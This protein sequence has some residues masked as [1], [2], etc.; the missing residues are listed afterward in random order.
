[1]SAYVIDYSEPLVTGF[2]IPAGG[3]NGPGGSQTNSTLRLYGRGALEWGEAVDED[4]LRLAENFASASPPSAAIAGQ[5]WVQTKLYVRN[6]LTGGPQ[7]GW[8]RYDPNAKTWSLLSGA[9]VAGGVVP[10]S[11]PVSPVV[12]SY[13]YGTRSVGTTNPTTLTGLWGYYSLG[14]YEPAAWV[15]RWSDREPF[16]TAGAPVNGVTL[17]VQRLRVRNAYVV[18]GDGAWTVPSTT[19]FSINAVTPIA[20][21]IGNL[22]FVTDTGQLRVYNG[23][24]WL[25]IVGPGA[26]SSQGILTMSGNQIKS[27]ADPSAAQD[28]VT[29]SYM[30]TYVT[31]AIAGG[32]FVLRSGDTMTGALQVST[33]GGTSIQTSGP[34]NVGG[35]LTASAGAHVAGANLAVDASLTV[36]GTGTFGSTVGAGGFSTG[37]NTSTQTLNVGGAGTINSLTVNTGLLVGSAAQFNSTINMTNHQINNVAN[38][39][40]TLDAV[41]KQYVDALIGGVSGFLPLTGGTLSGPGNLTVNGVLTANSTSVHNGNATFTTLSS[42]G[43]ATLANVTSSGTVSAAAGS[44]SALT[45]NNQKITSVANP[46]N[47]QDAATKAY[48]DAVVAPKLSTVAVA[49]PYLTGNGVVGTPVTVSIPNVKSA[50]F[51]T[52]SCSDAGAM[53]AQLVACGYIAAP[54]GGVGGTGGIGPGTG[55]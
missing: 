26:S 2:T 31:G 23:S 53:Y 48:V 10:V 25:S 55:G 40:N 14:R 46:T 39:T 7:N 15:L 29:L 19:A 41:N 42:S 6:N 22:W 33:G 13:Y 4:L 52:L 44:L 24:A 36:G 3:L 54:V 20:P 51:S 49:A 8:Y 47:P 45:M 16:E 5:L 17:P 9:N 12:G 1:M 28:A 43:T 50:I 18:A 35:L 27:L 11:P 21:E 37:G 38:P 30:Q 34:V 32:G